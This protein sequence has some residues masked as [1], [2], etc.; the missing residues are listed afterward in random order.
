VKFNRTQSTETARALAHTTLVRFAVHLRPLGFRNSAYLIGKDRGGNCH[1]PRHRHRQSVAG[2]IKVQTIDTRLTIARTGWPKIMR[3]KH[4]R[5][6]VWPCPVLSVG[7]S[8]MNVSRFECCGHVDRQPQVGL[9]SNMPDEQAVN[10]RQS[11][12]LTKRI[13]VVEDDPSVQKILKR[14]FETEGFAVEGHMDGRAG[15]DSFHADVPS[16]VILDLHLPRLSG[17][18]LCKEMKAAKPSIPVVILTAS[19]D[20]NDKVILLEMGADD[21]IT[22]PFSPRELLARIRV[23]LRHDHPPAKASEVMFDGIVVNFEK[24]EVTRNGAS[25]ALTAREFKTLRFFVQNPNRIITRAELLSKICGNEDGETSS[26]S[27]DN[28]VMK[29]RHKLEG[30]PSR[31]IHFRTVQSFGYRFVL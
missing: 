31:P 5:R 21:Y 1:V 4:E 8:E 24:M 17:Q 10:Q 6:L 19:Y 23:A 13:L 2:P 26:R 14:L 11:Q 27:I 30:D 12:E 20:L 3:R 22:K 7:Q 18:H 28:H 16:A 15:L 9:G 25:I 29:L